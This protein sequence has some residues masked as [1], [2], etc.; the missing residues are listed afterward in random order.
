MAFD[1]FLKLADVKGEAGDSKHKDEI[2]VYSFHWGATNAG[3]GAHGSGGGSGKVQISDFSFVHRLDKSSPVLFQKCATGEHIKDGLFVV[4]KAG[5]T[6]V[7]YLKIKM[8]DIVVSGI[9]PGGSAH[10]AD[11]IPLEEVSL[12]FSKVEVDYQPQGADGK[13][14]GGPVHGGWD[15]KQNVKA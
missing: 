7:E 11:D 4:R 9:H 14:A 6:Q 15:L 12:N 2:E 5:G 8:T 1:A 13:A 10:G 3:M